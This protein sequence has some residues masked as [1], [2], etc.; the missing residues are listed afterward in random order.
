MS[1]ATLV[2]TLL[3]QGSPPSPFSSAVGRLSKAA[4][5]TLFYYCGCQSSRT[6]WVYKNKVMSSAACSASPKT[7]Y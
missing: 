7:A 6:N 5:G 3:D 4:T 2:T 1:A